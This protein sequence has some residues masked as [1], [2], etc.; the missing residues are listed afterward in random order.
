MLLAVALISGCAPR[1]VRTGQRENYFPITAWELPGEK[2]KL[3]GDPRCGIASM[4]DC[5]FTVAAFP[6]PKQLGICDKLDMP[7][8]VSLPGPMVKW[9][10]LSDQQ[11]EETVRKLVDQS[12]N[13]KSV[14]G[15]FLTD[16]PGVSAFPALGKA[17]AAVKKLAPGKLAYI[18]LFPNYATLGA[19]DLSQLGTSSFTEYLE[20]YVQEVKPQFISYDNYQIQYSDDMKNAGIAGNYFVNLLEVRRIAMEHD[21]P[22]WN[23]V[24]SNEIRPNTTIPS[25]ANML[26]QAYT[27][28]AAGGRGLTWYTYYV[29]GYHYAPIDKAGNRTATWAHLKMVNEQVK[30]LGP[31]MNR[32]KS[33]GVFFS[34]PPP[35]ASLPVLPGKLIASVASAT[36]V[37]VGEFAAEADGKYVMLVNLSLSQSSQVSFKTLGSSGELRCV[38][39]VDASLSPLETPGAVWLTAGQGVLIKLR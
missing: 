31:V 18:N 29:G 9:R 10:E 15:Y 32:L 25:P 7:A 26:L 6:T 39:P 5:A 33:T 2:E 23:I 12:K 21:L 22:F 14:I 38:S 4:R 16:E 1:P 37:M 28:L 19:P 24:A 27:T 17:V 13:S 3:M 11:I 8:I 35:A 34:A 30:T 36:P 20:R